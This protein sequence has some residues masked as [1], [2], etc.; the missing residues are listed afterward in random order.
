MAIAIVTVIYYIL[1]INIKWETATN[2]IL[3]MNECVCVV[4]IHEINEKHTLQWL[5]KE[6]L[7]NLFLIISSFFVWF[8]F[9]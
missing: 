4:K 8:L 6:N 3:I 7:V 5:D 1:F 9:F 2:W